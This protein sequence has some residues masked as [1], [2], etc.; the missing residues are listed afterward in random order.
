MGERNSSTPQLK[1]PL[2]LFKNGMVFSEINL[3]KHPFNL[4]SNNRLNELLKEA[5]IQKRS[6]I[7]YE[8]QMHDGSTRIWRVKPNVET[9]YTRPFDKKVIVTVLKLAT[10]EGFPP[11]VIWKLGS[12]NRICRTMKIVNS[13]E[14]QRLVKESLLRI[15]DTTIYTETFYLKDK[16]EYWKEKPESIGGN[17]TLWSVFWRGDRLPDG[18]VAD[19][20][21]LAFNIP[22]I[23][24][25]QAYYVK[26]LDYDYWLSLP[27][28]AQRIYELTGLKF[29]GL[30][31]S[32]YVRYEYPELCQLLPIKP[33][34]N[35]SL[36][37]QILDRAHQCLKQTGWLADVEWLVKGQRALSANSPW[38][39]LYFPGPRAKSEIAQAK[40][41]LARF[42]RWQQRQLLCTDP[43]WLAKVEYLVREM[44]RV[45]GDT[46][47][48]G[49]FTKIAKMLPESVLWRFLSEVKLAHH[50]HLHGVSKIKRSL[51]AT[52]MD[53]VRRYCREHQLDIGVKF[54]K[55]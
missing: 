11:P 55:A 29:Y 42:K 7:N 16:K 20:I 12:L 33:Q 21:Y 13:G 52:F 39:L 36:A 4:L 34:K 40:Q 22:F 35:I 8:L 31:E 53:K 47:S 30:E 18:K 45:T 6:H 50:D 41:R 5:A 19:S 1:Q 23:L 51:A 54:Q 15:S 38:E 10:D 2:P 25:L 24:S 14:N 43:E 17:F 44:E 48:R 3:L 32:S 49:A 28:L 37:Q 26:P 27:P 9:G 46:H